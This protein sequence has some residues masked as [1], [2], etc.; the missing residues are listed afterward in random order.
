MGKITSSTITGHQE[1]GAIAPAQKATLHE[2]STLYI[3]Y[4]LKTLPEFKVFPWDHDPDHPLN[5]LCCWKIKT[6]DFALG[7]QMPL[8]SPGPNRAIL[9]SRPL[10]LKSN[11]E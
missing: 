1:G 4:Q 10:H 11:S 9:S 8:D 6:G 5:V 2:K 7:V 3:I